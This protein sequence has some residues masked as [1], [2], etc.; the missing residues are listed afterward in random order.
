MAP[1]DRT[2][3]E[4]LADELDH[5]SRLLTAY[6]EGDAARREAAAP[7]APTALNVA[8]AIGARRARAATFGLELAHPGWSLLLELYRARLAGEPGVR[9][10]RLA[11]DARLAP[12]TVDRWLGRLTAA[13]WAERVP[14]PKAENGVHA[15]L[16]PDGAAAMQAHF[17]AAEAAR[18]VG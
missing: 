4:E 18:L 16:T 5:L 3:L 8:L 13:G 17:E 2:F 7:G 15:R 11:V 6:A 1:P 10:N 12:A 9:I 14:D